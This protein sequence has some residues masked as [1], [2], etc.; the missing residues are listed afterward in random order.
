MFPRA[1]STRVS[2]IRYL[3]LGD[4]F[5]IGTGI[6][7]QS[8]FPSVLV[9]RWIARGIECDLTNPSVNGYTTDDL[10]REE[11]PLVV[12]VRPTLV[13][14]LVGANDLVRGSSEERYRAQ[15]RRIH[16]HLGSAGVP[17]AAV[18]ALPQ[19]DWSLS[20][21]GA[22]FGAPEA[23]ARSIE[24]F[25]AIAREEAERA[26][27]RYVDLFPLMREQARAAMLAHDGLHPSAEAHAQW[28]ERLD[29]ILI[30]GPPPGSPRP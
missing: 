10:I 14:L 12:R 21:A 1:A 26:T 17:R 7:A 19:P 3:A 2:A 25:N 16:D 8:A 6:E 5:T 4:S 27:S 13:T 28:A 22:A 20:P 11:L 9:R 23:I 30:P 24:R 15:L 29:R 18:H